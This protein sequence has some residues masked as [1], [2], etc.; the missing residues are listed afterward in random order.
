MTLF[1]K[2]Q[3]GICST[4]VKFLGNYVFS[5]FSAPIDGK[6]GEWRPWN[7]SVTCGNGI[8]MRTRL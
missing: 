3:H 6:W 2:V 8:D 5:L 1:I 7:C 4:I